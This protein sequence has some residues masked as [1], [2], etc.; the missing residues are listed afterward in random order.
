[1]NDIDFDCGPRLSIYEP[2]KYNCPIHGII[3]TVM[4]I[5]IYEQI[6]HSFCLRCYDEFLQKHIPL[7]F[8]VENAK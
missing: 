6:T 2:T 5:F 4:Q 7:V 8:P 3:D 1:M